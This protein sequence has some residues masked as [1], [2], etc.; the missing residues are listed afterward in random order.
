MHI[1]ILNSVL[2]L[3][4]SYNYASM[5]MTGEFNRNQHSW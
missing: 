2:N 3:Q 4:V 1:N 5:V